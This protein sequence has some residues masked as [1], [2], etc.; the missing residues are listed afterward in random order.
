MRRLILAYC[1]L[2][3]LGGCQSAYY[4]MMEK[5]GVHKRDILAD[6]VEAARDSQQA[7]KEQ[8]KDALERYRNVVQ[9]QGGDLEARY[10]ALERE[11]RASEASAK[12][13]RQRIA[14]VEDVAGALFEEWEG[15]LDQYSN[16]TLRR[17]S[18][19]EL[20]RTR[21]QYK[22]LLTRMQAAEKRIEPVLSV[23]RDQVLFLKHNLNARAIGAL[24]GEYRSLQGNVDQLLRDM[25]RSIDEADNFVRRLQAPLD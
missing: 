3:A 20:E 5:A 22:T 21:K 19:K 11:Y 8:F 12:A 15:E 13:V 23:L 17:A 7:A 4:S 25:Q 14:A 24:Q 6:R 16:A 2:L 1:T 10:V 18:A 9:V